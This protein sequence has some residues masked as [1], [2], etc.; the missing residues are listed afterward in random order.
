MFQPTL[1]SVRSHQIPDWYH[2]AKLGIFVHWGLYSVPAWAPLT[3]ELGKVIA[4]G[5]WLKWFSNNPYAEW[6]QNSLAIGQGA[7]YDHHVKT[8]GAD[9]TYEDFAP[10]Y[11]AA[12]ERFDAGKLADAFKRAGAQYAV[13]TTKHHEG[14]LL[15]PSAQPNPHKPN[16]QLKRDVV[17]ELTDAV[18]ARD[19]RMG[20]YYS[21][22]LDW[23]F[24]T[25]VIK[26]IS[27]LFVGVPQSPEYEAYATGHFRELIA[28]YKPSVMWNDIGYPAIA[29]LP[30]LFA[31][32][33]NAAPEGVINDRFI[34]AKNINPQEMMAAARMARGELG[35]PTAEHYDFKTPEYTTV[36]DVTPHKWESCRGLGFSFGYNQNDTDANML[37][38]EEL[39]RSLVDIVSKNGNLLLNVGPM[40]DGSLPDNQLKRLEGLGDWLAVNSEAIYSTRPWQRAEGKA[41]AGDQTIPVRFTRKGDALYATLLETPKSREVTLESVAAAPGAMVTLLGHDARLA[42]EQ[43]GEHMAMTLPEGIAPMPAH[44]IRITPTI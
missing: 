19:M 22:G 30:R 34:Q 27:D 5:G 20:L 21:G 28:R 35:L 33:Y 18:R 32:Y 13:L 15:W 40:A 17:G 11:Q 16:W 37:S 4:E 25:H 14:F 7:T 44:V 2:D 43:R 41:H 26:D 29:D 39:V 1:D 38:V 12:A 9:F 31:D 8:Y 23:T 6:Y 10:L 3:G 36:P 42:W 24:N